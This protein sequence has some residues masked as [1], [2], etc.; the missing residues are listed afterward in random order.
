MSKVVFQLV[1]KQDRVS[2]STYERKIARDR[3]YNELV[4]VLS[5]HSHLEL[6]DRLR[7]LSL[8]AHK[9]KEELSNNKGV[10]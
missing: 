10:S 5:R 2:F 1:S 3:L 8:C 7:V 9:V 6:Y 4:V